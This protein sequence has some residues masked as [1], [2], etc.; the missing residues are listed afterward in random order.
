MKT[1][2]ILALVTLLLCSAALAGE[3]AL[4]RIPIVNLPVAGSSNE[5]LPPPS[6]VI[7]NPHPNPWGIDDPVGTLDTVGTTWYDYQHNGTI[8]RMIAVD[9]HDTV[10]VVWMNGLDNGA[11]NRHVYYN[12]RDTTGA[13]LFGNIGNAVESAPRAGYTVVDVGTDRRAYP[14]FHVI[15]SGNPRAHTAVA[16]DLFP[17]S[18]AFNYWDA[19]YVLIQG[20]DIQVFWPQ[21]AI[22]IDDVVH[23]FDCQEMVAAG[24]PMAVYYLTGTYGS[25]SMDFTDRTMVDT[26]MDI[27]QAVAASRI[28]NR[29]AV[30]WTKPMNA[31]VYNSQFNNDIYAVIS[32]DGIT[33]DFT[34]PIN[35]TDFIPPDSSLLPDTLAADRDT[36]RVYTDINL[37]FDDDDDLHVAFTTPAYYALEELVSINNSMI[38]HWD[39]SAEF[40]SLVADGWWGA[41]PTCGA[42]QRYVQRPCLAQDANTGWLYCLYHAYDTSD[43]AANGFPQGELYVSVSTD[44]GIHWSVGINITNTHAPGAQANYCLSER[45]PSMD[46]IVDGVLRILYVLDKDA[47]ASWNNESAWTLNP[48]IYHE[49]PVDSIPTTPLVPSY[50]MHVDST[51]IPTA[52]RLVNNGKVPTSFTLNQNYPNPFNPATRI[53]F[54]LSSTDHV[55]LKVY[56]TLGRTVAELVDATL[57]PGTYQAVFDG[58]DLSSGVYFYALSTPT[59]LQTRKMVLLK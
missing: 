28:S 43:V 5:A 38:W 27:A 45:D 33:W 52:V 37:F 41:G 32:E 22:D 36:F 46:E 24:D 10:H 9:N 25:L 50:P 15:R 18:G 35:V 29:V 57:M 31:P 17:P 59:T 2:G 34:N 54:T 20:I 48:V 49:V 39:E 58:A 47:G 11:V 7:Y 3:R 16:A 6:D 51:G 42:W 4:D 21:I 13:W 55:T 8:G 23:I 26:T 40:Y 30:A 1:F 19:P 12:Q 14:S 44:E 53:N 56:N